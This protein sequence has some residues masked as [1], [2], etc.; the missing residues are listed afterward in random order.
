IFN[1]ISPYLGLKTESSFAMF[2][3]LRTE[4]GKSNHLLIPNS[5]QLFDFQKDLVEIES[6]SDS[7][8]N[9]LASKKLALPYFDFQKYAKEHP[10][11]IATYL[12]NGKTYDLSAER[13]T[14][15]FNTEPPWYYRVFL[16]FRPVSLD[17]EMPCTR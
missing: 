11:I 15:E 4:G 2:S 1:G 14:P 16:V 12:R 13:Q 7:Y 5:W 17:P 6:S 10:D 3:N 8:L 9:E